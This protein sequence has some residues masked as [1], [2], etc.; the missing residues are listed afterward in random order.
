MLSFLVTQDYKLTVISICPERSKSK[1][2]LILIK[3]SETIHKLF[4]EM[5]LHVI[6]HPQNSK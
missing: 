3:V 4:G 6:G 5:D 2:S 1:I